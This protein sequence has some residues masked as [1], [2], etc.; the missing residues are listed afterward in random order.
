MYINDVHAFLI[1]RA[2]ASV[3]IPYRHPRR[4]PLR[5]WSQRAFLYDSNIHLVGASTDTQASPYARL[6]QGQYDADDFI[7]KW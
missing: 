2:S 3:A 1:A 7:K 6:S 4:H 5:P